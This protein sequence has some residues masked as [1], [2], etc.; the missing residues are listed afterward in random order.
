MAFTVY[1]G[2]GMTL[3]ADAHNLTGL[4]EV[5]IEDAAKPAVER[6][7]K[8]TAAS[9]AYEFMDDPLGPKGDPK[10]TVIVRCNDSTVGVADTQG[11]HL[12]LG[13]SMAI[14]FVAGA[15]GSD[16]YDHATMRLQKRVTRC[17]HDGLAT[18]ELTF[19]ALTL[20][21]WGTV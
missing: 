9:S 6:L 18:V 14:A 3:S 1:T 16:K 17:P 20:G 10:A 4:T 11:H 8:T 7:D 5:S 2:K 12:T 19:E 13:A 15:A 21:T